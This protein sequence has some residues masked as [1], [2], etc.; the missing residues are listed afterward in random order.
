MQFW[1]R[2]RLRC[3]GR[4]GRAGPAAL[5]CLFVL[6]ATLAGVTNPAAAATPSTPATSKRTTNAAV[7]LSG[8]LSYGFSYSVA[9]SCPGCRTREHLSLT[10]AVTGQAI[11]AS[12]GTA[13]DYLDNPDVYRCA[14]EAAAHHDCFWVPLTVRSASARYGFSAQADVPNGCHANVSATGT[15]KAVSTPPP[16]GLDVVFNP[17]GPA[18]N[19]AAPTV[20]PG[21]SPVPVSGPT[22][23]PPPGSYRAS[24]NVA[25]LMSLTYT[26]RAAA[27]SCGM[28]LPGNLVDIP[29][30]FVGPY[31]SSQTKIQGTATYQG[32]GSPRLTWDLSLRPTGLGITSPVAGSTIALTDKHY[33]SPQPGPNQSQPKTRFLTVKG[34]DT[35]PGASV[36]TIG[37]AS[38]HVASDGAWSLK[39]PVA[40]TGKITLTAH[41]NAGATSTDALTLIDLVVTSPTEGAV[42]PVTT[43]PSM[44]DL[45]A[46]VSL[47]GYSGDVSPVIFHWQLSVRGKYRDRCGHNPV[48]PCGQWYSYNNEISSG[49][50]KGPAPWDGDFKTIEGGFGRISVSA[51]VPGVLDEPVQSE[52]RW[53]NIYGTNPS[54]ATIKAYVSAK[55][56]ANAPVEDKLFCH[57]SRFMQFDPAPDPREPA[58]KMVPHDIGKN[59]APLQ[60]LFGAQ[61]A[62]IGIAQK[63]PSSFPAEQWDWQANVDAGIAVYQEDLAEARVWYQ[64]EQS[65]LTGQLNAVLNVVN[66]ERQMHH[67]KPV[68][69][70][71]AKVPR[72]SPAQ[73]KRE[74]VRQY[75][76]EEE[77]RFS[78]QY[79]VSQNHLS[80][81]VAGKGKWVEGAGEWQPKAAWKA[82]GGPL[83]VRKWEPAQNPGYVQLV[84]ACNL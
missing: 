28:K 50:T 13:G 27:A 79:V 43:T 42:L 80:V 81:R 29:V 5:L 23:L 35:S 1:T 17:G 2:N 19:G 9:G 32:L 69:M 24:G 33:F 83:V 57:E 56:P 4:F 75:N 20:A 71:A 6:A 16:L 7:S 74:A 72:L 78:R 73:V 52:P 11:N 54:I 15:Y 22:T 59:P 47:E 31:R 53:V 21:P 14:M 39:V 49:T 67:M 62:G 37:S 70:V 25:V 58:T 36:V 82:A 60:P 63:D 84:E 51:T 66:H 8:T 77:Y 40:R 10:M 34:T 65:R 48:A 46:K 55:D 3:P 44:P 38:T 76:G 18:Q 68:K 45:G 12:S 64:E 61:Y 26:D 30:G 41:D